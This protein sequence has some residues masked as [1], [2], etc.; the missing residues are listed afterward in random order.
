MTDVALCD[1][2]V[3]DCVL[4]DISKIELSVDEGVRSNTMWLGVMF[5]IE[6]ALPL[7]LGLTAGT[8]LSGL[9]SVSIYFWM[10][11]NS[12]IWGILSLL[13]PFSYRAEGLQEFYVNYFETAGLLGG[14]VVAGIGIVLWLVSAITGSDNEWIFFGVYTVAEPLLTWI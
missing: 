6:F 8:S 12:L 1:P 2:L 4:T 11:V 14:W 3:D 13:W 9:S 10:G 7:A 5:L